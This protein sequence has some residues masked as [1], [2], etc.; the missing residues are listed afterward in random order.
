MRRTTTTLAAIAL[1]ITGIAATPDASGPENVDHEVELT[2]EGFAVQGAPDTGAINVWTHMSIW[3]GNTCSSSSPDNRCER[4]LVHV[5]E[6]GEAT[7]V[8]QAAYEIADYDLVVFE[9]GPSGE[10]F[11]VAGHEQSEVFVAG[12]GPIPVPGPETVT[13]EVDED[14]WLLAVVFYRAA[15]GGFTLTGELA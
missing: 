3:D 10:A 6:G 2:A 4:V 9:S 5:R 1:A 15:G 7:F 11:G 13:L 12:E 14:S 8:L